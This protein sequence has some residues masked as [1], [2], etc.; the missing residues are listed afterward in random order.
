MFDLPSVG[1]AWDWFRRELEGSAS[2]G[3]STPSATGGGGSTSTQAPGDATQT[4]AAQG[5]LPIQLVV[6]AGVAVLLV[7]ALAVYKGDA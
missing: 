7:V 5:G 2:G 4:P 6:V 1:D 3:G